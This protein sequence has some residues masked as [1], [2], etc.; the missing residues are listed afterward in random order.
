M[1]LA[2]FSLPIIAGID[3]QF[4]GSNIEGSFGHYVADRAEKEV[5]LQSTEALKKVSGVARLAFMNQKHTNKIK[6]VDENNFG[7]SDYICDGQVTSEKGVALIVQTADC[8]PILFFDD[9]KSVIGAAHAGWKG[10]IGGVV[11]NTVAAMKKLGAEQISAFIGPCIRQTS[12]E[13]DPDFHDQFCKD[14]PDSATFFSIPEDRPHK[15]LFD[16]PSY[17]KSQLTKAGIKNI[18][19]CMVNTYTDDQLYSFR[20]YTHFG[21]DYGSNISMISLK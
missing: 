6:Q 9:D 2:N 4:W 19:D 15:Y 20:R 3:I 5:I 11:E 21:D 8:V 12:Y 7:D 14:D 1:K 16:L 13:V 10:A 17:V 18:S